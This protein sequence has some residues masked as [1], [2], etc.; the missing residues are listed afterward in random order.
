MT[1]IESVMSEEL[2]AQNGDP[3][4]TK[5][6][7]HV[8]EETTPYVV[9]VPRPPDKVTL[10]DF[11]AVL[12]RSNFKFYCKSNDDEVGGEVKAEIRDDNAVLKRSANGLIELFLLTAEGSSHSD[13]S[14]GQKRGQVG[15]LNHVPPG[16]LNAVAHFNNDQSMA[17]TDSE[18][19]VS[20]L[21]NLPKYPF[22]AGINRRMVQPQ[23]FGPGH[24]QRRMGEN[25][26][27]MTSESDARMFD[28]ED[29]RSRVSTSTDITSV[30]RQQQNL[31]RKRR[32]RKTKFRQPSRASSFSSIT[33]SSMSL[34]IIAIVLN[35]DTVSFLGISIVGQSSQRG[36]GGIYVANIMKGGA[37]ALDGRIEAGDMILQVNEHSFENLT[38]DEAVAVLRDAVTRKGPIKLVVA[39]CWDSGPKSCFTLPR[40]KEEPVRPIDTLAW[41]HHTNAMRAM[42]SILEGSE[43]APTPVPGYRPPSSGTV[44]SNSGSH[45][46]QHHGHFDQLDT[47]M[48]PIVIIK[49]LAMPNSG[50][51]IRNRTWLKIPIPMSFLGSDLVDWLLKMVHGLYDRKD[52]RKYAANLLRN[53]FIKHVV[54]KITFTEQCYY[55]LG[56]VCADFAHMRLNPAPEEPP[57]SETGTIGPLPPP[58]SNQMGGTSPWPLLP[59]ASMVSGYA[60]MPPTSPY[61]PQL[62]GTLP[63]AP[64]TPATMAM[65]GGVGRLVEPAL[66]HASGSGGSSGSDKRQTTGATVPRGGPPPIPPKYTV[67]LHNQPPSLVNINLNNSNGRLEELPKD[68]A[69]SRNSFRI[70]MSNPCEFFV[71][72]L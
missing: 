43:G 67:N 66:S 14:A 47:S 8:D 5:V 33:E 53:H 10:G 13:G 27:M 24:R 30:S 12:N 57:Q 56:D 18:S 63:T 40:H 16:Y 26:S 54:N 61:P 25:D 3:A 50:L 62:F 6:Y 68:L 45:D 46:G 11:K 20:G 22:K 72:N 37:V 32:S 34:N 52:A 51:D 21:A 36:D 42:P 71:D 38:N 64:S 7:Y 15:T 4:D 29:D 2:P 28:S 59:S 9:R 39:K 49:A 60:S 58:P 55:V 23:Y 17:S 48:D 19:M 1:D 35:M 31:Y 44:T 70:A 41:V 65:G 69:S